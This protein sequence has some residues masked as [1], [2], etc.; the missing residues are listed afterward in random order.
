MFSFC[1]ILFSWYRIS[2]CSSSPPGIYY[3]AQDY[4]KLI[5][6]S[7]ASVF[8]VLGLPVWATMPVYSKQ[9]FTQRTNS[10]N[11]WILLSFCSVAQSGSVSYI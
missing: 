3:I 7:P 9:F 10:N 11:V 4:L 5:E 2:L 1:F 8:L 6:N